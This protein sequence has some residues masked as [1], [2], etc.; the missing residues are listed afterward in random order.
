MQRED[1]MPTTSLPQGT[2]SYVEHGAAGAPAVV[3]VHGILVDGTLWRSV[4][5]AVAAQGFRCWVPDLP[6]G[7]HRR[8]M[9]PD[10][11]LTPRGVA[12]L[13]LDFLEHHD[14]TDVC[15]VANDTGGAITQFLLDIDDRRVSSVLF[16]NCDAFDR[17][18][19]PPFKQL[20]HV[21]KLPGAL[22]AMLPGL[23]VTTLRHLVGYGPLMAQRPDAAQTRSWV[24]PLRDGAVR[25]DLRKVLRGIDPAD[26]QDVSTRLAQFAGPV[27]CVWGT[28]DRFF[29]AADGR[30]LAECFPGG[31]FIGVDGA[32]TFVA[33]DQPERL[34]A[35]LVG[36]LAARPV[37][38]VT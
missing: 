4:A 16:T 23:R 12:R 14:L 15:L 24:E 6:L 2:I 33:L 35:E 25:R 10:A 37:G 26:L 9:D 20:F 8:A 17:F 28:A 29:R 3:F 11:D 18:P 19:P 21:A 31:S 27:R 34:A 32:S 13:L 7:S 30:R 1:P 5:P 22:P 36:F 38:P